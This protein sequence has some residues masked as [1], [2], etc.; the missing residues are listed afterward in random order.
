MITRFSYT[1]LKGKCC[2]CITHE[3]ILGPIFYP[4]LNPH[5]FIVLSPM[6]FTDALLVCKMLYYSCV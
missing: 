6:F 1:E 3:N 2:K 4:L 5:Q